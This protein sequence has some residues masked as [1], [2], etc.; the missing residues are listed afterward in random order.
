M[1]QLFSFYT[2]MNEKIFV[3]KLILLW[4]NVSDIYRK[5]QNTKDLSLSHTK[6]LLLREPRSAGPM[7]TF[8]RLGPPTPFLRIQGCLN[9]NK[10]NMS[11]S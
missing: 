10:N 7:D 8:Q 9:I 3:L 5:I 4:N 6:V 11:I 2:F 1:T